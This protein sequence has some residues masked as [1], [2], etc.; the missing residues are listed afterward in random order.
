MDVSL[1]LTLQPKF[2]AAH[3]WG[4]A[5]LNSLCSGISHTQLCKAP[6]N[7]GVRGQAESVQTHCDS[8]TNTPYCPHLGQHHRG[9]GLYSFQTPQFPHWRQR[10][11]HPLHHGGVWRSPHP[12][13]HRGS[14]SDTVT[15]R[16]PAQDVE[17]AK[18]Q[19]L[20]LAEEKVSFVLQGKEQV[21]LACCFFL[22]V[23]VI[24]SVCVEAFGIS[25]TN[26]L[27]R[28]LSTVW[29]IK[30]KL[31]LYPCDNEFFSHG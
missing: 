10:P 20:H 19:L 4:V 24:P 14:G 17:K 12:L 30:R 27:L 9:G 2:V 11:L 23:E 28:D 29:M 13:P 21:G 26:L 8:L 6:G 15:I 7:V 1:F 16:G 3:V 22:G 5:N 25:R 18:K 31:Y